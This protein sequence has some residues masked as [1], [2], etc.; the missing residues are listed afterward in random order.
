MFST[1][2]RRG[3]SLYLHFI[4]LLYDICCATQNCSPDGVMWSQH[5][6]QLARLA[7]PQEETDVT[8]LQAYILWYA[9]FLDAQSCF[10]GNPESGAFVRAYLANGSSLPSWRKPQTPDRKPSPEFVALAAVSNLSKYMCTS[11]A[12]LSQLAV[13]MRVDFEAGRGNVLEH[14]ESVMNFRNELHASW[15]SKYPAFLPR[16]IL[17]AGARLPALARTIFDFV[18][19]HLLFAGQS[20]EN[21]HLTCHLGLPGV[22][23]R[24]RL[25]AHKHVPWPTHTRLTSPTQGNSHPL[26]LNPRHGRPSRRSQRHRTTS[27]HLLRLLSRRQQHQR[28]RQESRCWYHTRHGR[29]WYQ[30]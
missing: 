24:H 7:Y 19:W 2:M 18:S 17:E 27:H 1:D 8:E 9:L 12:I 21:M 26:P 25:L 20:Q 14:Q 29:H 6:Q 3:S 4:L 10:A 16:D 30:L 15:A 11:F 13:Q 28:P 22:F 5:F 23:Y